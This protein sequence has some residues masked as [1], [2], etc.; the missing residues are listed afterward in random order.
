MEATAIRQAIPDSILP[1]PEG[2]TNRAKYR[3][4]KAFYPFH[5]DARN[6][7][8]AAHVLKH[9]G[10]QQYFFGALAPGLTVE[11]FLKHLESQ[12]FGNHFVAWKDD[13]ESFSLRRPDGFERQY[14]VR[15][16]KDG[17]VRG[18]YEFT[19]E[20]YPIKHLKAIGQEERRADFLKFFGDWVVS[21]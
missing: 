15:I 16:F 6:L 2:L 21:Q 1:Y 4:W 13:D 14:H 5:N 12:N 10:R 17:E 3:L 11:G 19:P 7:L 20:C 9:E 18:H 8:L